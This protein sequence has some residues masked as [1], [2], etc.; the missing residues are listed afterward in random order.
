MR[1]E[2]NDEVNVAFERAEWKKGTSCAPVAL[3]AT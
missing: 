1:S 3:L 2:A